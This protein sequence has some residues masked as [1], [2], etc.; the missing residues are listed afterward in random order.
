MR[1]LGAG[2]RRAQLVP[3]GAR[4]RFVAALAGGGADRVEVVRPAAV[5]RI[6]L[7]L[8]AG[9]HRAARGHQVLAAGD[10]RYTQSALLAVSPPAGLAGVV[11][12]PPIA[13]V[14]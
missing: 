14:A 7:R 5:L 12:V 8:M 6:I 9:F 13:P 4:V 2:R 3:A 10:I 1:D 11:A